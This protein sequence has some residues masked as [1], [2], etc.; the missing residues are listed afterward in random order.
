L[1]PPHAYVHLMKT[2]KILVLAANPKDTNRLRI[3]EEVREIQEEFKRANQRED[4]EIVSRWAVRPSDVQ[5]ALLD[6]QPHVVHFS[7]HGDGEAGLALENDGGKTQ[8]VGAESLGRLFKLFI[9]QIECV[10]LNACYSEVQANAIYQHIDYVIGMKQQIGDKAAVK[11]AAGFYRALGAGRSYEDAYEFGCNAI[12][13]ESVPEYLTPV[14]KKRVNANQFKQVFISYRTKDPDLEIAQ[15]FYEALT[16]AGHKVFMAAESIR[17]GDSWS[18]RIQQQ[19]EH[20]DYFLVL[21]SSQSVNSEMVT[22]EIRLARMLRDA[23]PDRRPTILPIRIQFPLTSPLNYDQ[24]GYLDQIQQREWASDADTARIIREILSILTG[25]HKERDRQDREGTRKQYTA[26]TYALI[27]PSQDHPDDPPL[28]VAEPELR[29]DPRGAV[30]LESG[31]YVERP[32]IEQDCYAEITQPGALICIRAPRQ[33]GKTSLMAR[34]LSHAREWN[35]QTISISFQRAEE[36]LFDDLDQF[37]HWLAEQIGRRLKQLE[38][39]DHYWQQG[40]AKD[41]CYSYFEECLLEKSQTPIV[42]GLD[43]VDRV[44]SHRQVADEFFALLRSWFDAARI[45]DNSSDLWQKLRLILVHST[46]PYVQLE[47]NQSPFNVGMRVRL[48]EFDTKQVQDLTYRYGLRWTREEVEQLIDFVGG[49][50]YLVRKALYHIRRQDVTLAQLPET[51]ATEVSIYSDHLK[52]HLLHLHQ[53]PELAQALFQVA[54]ESKAIKIDT[55]LAFKLE[56]MGLIR[57]QGNE[58]KPRC[59]LYRLYFREHLKNSSTTK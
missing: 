55:Q 30:F 15:Q 1:L 17:L 2:K 36:R 49:H 16:K 50:P 20:C 44:F 18:K 24:R 31:L 41:K 45:G 10:V 53:H 29:R 25:E 59:S 13:L 38:Q 56:S 48:P 26:S 5:R 11:F 8:L 40:A 28:P 9:N 35:Y 3:D 4:F 12:D 34:I 43:E 42:V 52:N 32:P 46:E 58:V 57:L 22:Q 27:T 21:L 14:L 7:G 51:A 19:L 54:D 37:L 6:F 33:M 39:L 23:R 47:M